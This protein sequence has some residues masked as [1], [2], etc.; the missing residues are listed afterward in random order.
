MPKIIFTKL[1]VKDR[2]RVMGGNNSS[3]I[4]II[5]NPRIKYCR[6]ESG[7]FSVI[8]DCEEPG[9]EGPESCKVMR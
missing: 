2:E 1:T 5:P 4:N 6:A 9:S 8:S 3:N 7:P